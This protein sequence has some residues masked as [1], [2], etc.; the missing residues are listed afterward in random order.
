[1]QALRTYIDRYSSSTLSDADFD[2]VMG[3][4]TPKKLRR[5]QYLLQAGEVCKYFAFVLRGALRQYSVD[6]K[7]LEHIMHFAVENWWVGDRESFVMLT[8]SR[9]HIDALEDCDLLLVTNAGLQ[10]LIRTVPAIAVM[11]RN[12]TSATSLPRRSGC[13][14]PSATVPKNATRNWSRSTRITCNGFPST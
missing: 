5:R 9:Y 4:F 1:M 8:P 2:V 14:P 6:E 11:V 10:D 13:T 12:W 3:A 7:G